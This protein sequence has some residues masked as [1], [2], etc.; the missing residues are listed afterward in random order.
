MEAAAIPVLRWKTR[1]NVNVRGVLFCQKITT[2]ARV[3]QQNL[4]DSLCSLDA[5]S[6]SERTFLL[7]FVMFS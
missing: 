3:G 5:E 4:P 6:M 2:L 7:F 1:T